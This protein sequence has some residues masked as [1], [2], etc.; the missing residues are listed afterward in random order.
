[1]LPVEQR[2]I[3][4]LDYG[5]RRI[6]ISISDPLRI[7]ATS[8]G[9]LEHSRNLWKNLKEIIDQE[10]VEFVVVGMPLNLKGEKGQKAEEVA[11]FIE[12]LQT[13][14]GIDVITWD[15]RFTTSMARDSIMRMGTKK[16]GRQ[17]S[18]ERIDA[19]AAAIMLQGFLD[20]KKHSLSC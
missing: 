4:G 9:I 18:R 16:K 11:L 15:E 12:Q 20:R 10:D 19:M 3:L 8:Y 7:V 1:M 14:C 6:G 17:N 5:S 13:R 2:R